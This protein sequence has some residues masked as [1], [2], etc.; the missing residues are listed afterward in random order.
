MK[1]EDELGKVQGTLKDVDDSSFFP[2]GCQIY[3]V[4]MLVALCN[5]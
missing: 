4:V 2:T 5:L 1:Q 3:W